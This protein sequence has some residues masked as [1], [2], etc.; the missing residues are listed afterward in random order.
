MW[1]IMKFL[2]FIPG[3]VLYFIWPV[4]ISEP[5]GIFF[6]QLITTALYL[7]GAGM[8]LDQ[9]PDLG[10]YTFLERVSLVTGLLFVISL[11][12]IGIAFSTGLVIY[13]S[14]IYHEPYAEWFLILPAGTAL[15]AAIILFWPIFA[16]PIIWPLKTGDGSTEED[17][18]LQVIH[19]GLKYSFRTALETTRNFPLNITGPLS[20]IF[21]SIC[22]LASAFYQGEYLVLSRIA[23]AFAFLPLVSLYLVKNTRYCFVNIFPLIFRKMD[24]DKI[25]RRIQYFPVTEEEK[26]YHAAVNGDIRNLRAVLKKSQEMKN[27]ISPESYELAAQLV[28]AVYRKDYILEEKLL[29][30]ESLSPADFVVIMH[31]YLLKVFFKAVENGC[32]KTVGAILDGGGDVNI[33]D[34]DGNTPL[35]IAARHNRLEIAGLLL[36]SGADIE[37]ATE[38]GYTPIQFAR[39][40]E[41]R[42]FLRDKGAKDD[43]GVTH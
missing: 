27:R 13:V 19:P 36:E 11:I 34:G 30:S 14:G 21:L 7:G 39:T 9:I 2:V 18:Y 32:A 25:Y 3:I 24:R 22:L 15:T 35:N 33:A 17:W 31:D 4:L 38:R 20:I 37:A 8:Y 28:S 12:F 23:A 10:W 40:P 5:V 43:K 29:R 26:F 42:A 6:L 16:F 41:M 1:R